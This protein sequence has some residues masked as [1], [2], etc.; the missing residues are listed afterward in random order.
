MADYI[1]KISK[2]L[3]VERKKITIEIETIKNLEIERRRII[4]ESEKG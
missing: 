2:G 1:E 3:E 4:I